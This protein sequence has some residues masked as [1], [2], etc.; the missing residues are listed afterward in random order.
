MADVRVECFAA[1]D[2]EKDSAENKESTRTIVHEKLPGLERVDR[3]EYFGDA[4]DLLDAEDGNHYKPEQRHWP[5]HFADA[6]R[7]ARLEQKK[8]DQYSDGNRH[9]IRIE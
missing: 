6:G 5:K 1:G 7:P 9:D 4:V 3:R 8:S 2:R